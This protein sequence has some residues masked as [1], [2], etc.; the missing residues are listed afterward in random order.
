MNSK[1]VLSSIL[2][3]VLSSSDSRNQ[4]IKNNVLGSFFNKGCNI[5]LQLLLV[6][7][8]LHY[9][10]AN[11][12]GIWLTLSSVVLWLGMF[13]IGFSLGLKN[14]LTE[15]IANADYERGKE[16]VSTTYVI[17]LCVFIPLCILLEFIIPY[18]NW[19]TFLNVSHTYNLEITQVMHVL[20]LCVC[21]QMIVITI[22][23]VLASFQKVAL[24]GFFTVIANFI[25]VIIIYFLTKYTSP[26]MLYL[27]MTISFVPILIYIVASL[28]FYCGKLKMVC[29]SIKYYRKSLIREIFG[30]GIKFFVINVQVIAMYQTTNILISNISTP[31]DVTAYNIGYKY[32]STA[33]M[34]FS[35]MLSPFWPAFTDAFTRKDFPWMNRVFSKLTK[36]YW[37][38]FLLVVLMVMCSPV[39]YKLWVGSSTIV[40]WSM[41]IS[42]GIYIII[43]S[44]L[45]IMINLLN[46]IGSIKL[47]SI[48]MIIGVCFHIPFS[49][50]LGRYIGAI[51]VVVSMTI[52]SAI[53]GIIF[54]KQLKMI[55]ART[56]TGIWLK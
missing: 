54:T 10:D 33:L 20:V 9:L 39:V 25:S 41:S 31:H 32:I 36:L 38:V 4:N 17:L 3:K 14:K 28:Y 26:S 12:Y 56:A 40:P 24:G 37:G 49:L 11:V 47:Q 34:I 55:L 43:N 23:T 8:T 53:Y 44:W 15:S 7:M 5:L 51:G 18:I 22:N 1:S 16:L 48:I 27:S 50:L 42:I 21:I 35:L 2:K 6:P 13:D 29:P 30:L 52:L 46:G 19:S 45:A